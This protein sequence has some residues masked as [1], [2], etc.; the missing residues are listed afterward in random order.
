M[1]EPLDQPLPFL[2]SELIA[3]QEERVF[4]AVVRT[5]DEFLRWLCDSSPGLQWLQVEGL[6]GDAESWAAAAQGVGD[7][8]LDVIMTHPDR[9]FGHLYRLVDV[10]A[11]RDVRVTIPAAAGLMKAVRLAASLGLPIRVAPG[12]PS[13]EALA[14]F[15][16]AAEFYLRDSMVQ[17]PVEPFHSMLAAMRGAAVGTLWTITEDDPAVFAHQDADGCATLPRST[18]PA[19]PEFVRGHLASLIAEGA[20]CADC[21][22]Q[23]LCGGY[24]KW[25]DR[26]YSCAGVKQLFARIEAAAEEIGQDLADLLQPASVRPATTE[27]ATTEGELL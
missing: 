18:Q 8:P 24:F 2:S 9:Q 14:Q 25:P 3:E 19:P 11:A 16:E 7:V 20:E 21:P 13:E 26:A 6:L 22:W 15:D 23:E 27:A 17:A 5:R 10:R 4:V 12:Q 1:T